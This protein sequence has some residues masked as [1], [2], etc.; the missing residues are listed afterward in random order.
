MKQKLIIALVVLTLLLSGCSAGQ[1][2]KVSYIGADSA[3]TVAVEAAGIQL[4]QATFSGVDMNTRE[5]IDYYNVRFSSG[6]QTYEYNVDALTGRLIEANVPPAKTENNT[7]DPQT[8]NSQNTDS[9]TTDPATQQNQISPSNG[10]QGTTSGEKKELTVDEVK[11][12]ALAHAGVKASDVTFVKSGKDWD[13]GR[14]TYDLEFYTKDYREFDYDIDPYTGEILS[15]DHD[16]EYY[17]KPEPANNNSSGTKLSADEAK[18][19]ALKQVPGA[20]KDNI[21]EFETDYDDG[22]LEYEGKIY[23]NHMEYEFEIDGYSGAI[24]SW[25]VESIYD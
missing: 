12:I 22:R 24:R 3:K 2:N 16:A 15:F 23:Y 8:D 9:G 1:P 25:E 13:D 10:T 7:V 14:M 17:K 21:R 19:I 6:G 11:A 20:T 4:D 18:A 5:G